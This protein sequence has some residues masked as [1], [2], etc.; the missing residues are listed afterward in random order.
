M[1]RIVTIKGTADA[2]WKVILLLSSN[3]LWKKMLKQICLFTPGQLFHLWEGQGRGHGGKRRPTQDG[4]DGPGGSDRTSDRKERQER[5]RGSEDDGGYD[6]AVRQP[7]GSVGWSARRG[8][9][10]LHGHSGWWQS[11]LICYCAYYIIFYL[12]ISLTTLLPDNYWWSW[13]V[14]N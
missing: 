12:V 8:F 3:V 6:Q 1:E 9:W 2:C 11:T 4:V 13:L 14:T 7:E 10:Q 5:A